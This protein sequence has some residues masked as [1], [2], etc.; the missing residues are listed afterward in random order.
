MGEY[1]L[2]YILFAPFSGALALIF[3]SNR[4]PLLVRSIAA[5]AACRLAARVA[6]SL[7]CL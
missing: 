7:L 4:Q 2:L 1:A 5:G 3:V 6:L